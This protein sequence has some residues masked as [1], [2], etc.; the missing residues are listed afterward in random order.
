[1]KK[2]N[3]L[4][5]CLLAL[6]MTITGC[7]HEDGPNM[8]AAK[9]AADK[10][11]EET[12]DLTG[13]NQGKVSEEEQGKRAVM[14][15]VALSNVAA[16]L[17]IKLAGV[18]TSHLGKMPHRYDN[19]IQIGLPM[20]PNMEVTKSINPTMV[21]IPD[22]LVDWIDEGLNKHEIPH[23]YCNLRS[24]ESLYEVT[25]DLAEEYGKMD[26][27]KEL[28][29][30][31]DKFFSE[32]NARIKDKKK[33]RVL[34]LMGLPGSYLVATKNSF[35]GNLV[36]HSGAINIVDSKNEFEQPNLEYLLSQKPDYILRTVHAMPDI[37]NKM[38]EEE[39]KT[40]PAW[41]HFDAVKNNKV[42]DLDSSVFG[43]TGAFDYT[44][45]LLDLEELF[46]KEG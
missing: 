43:M 29:V 9:D 13:I 35:A 21:Y 33:P 2:K 46:Y 25:K 40:N 15:S 34:V 8:K 24:V 26:K 11:F 20:N 30:E 7:G 28:E 32:Y 39:F 27:Y 16:A 37:V 38:F 44:K 6:S 4:I 41:Q 45:G 36:A 10:A 12:L 1:M 14:D 23:K 18:P 5:S 3:I 22:S 17:D 19:I 31:R 42:I